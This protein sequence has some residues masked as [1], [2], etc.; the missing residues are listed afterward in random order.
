LSFKPE[1][2]DIREAPSLYIIDRLIASGAEVVVHDPVAMENARQR[3]GDIVHYAK[4]NYDACKGACGL[5][6]NTEWNEYRQPDFTKMKDVMKDCVIF[7]GR[8]L[9]DPVKLEKHGFTYFGVGIGT[10]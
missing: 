2:D 9:Y 5:V 4:S 3:F 6:I 1:T 8:N 10:S 7:D